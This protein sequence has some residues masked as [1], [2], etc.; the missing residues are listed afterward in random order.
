MQWWLPATQSV[1]GLPTLMRGVIDLAFE[2][3]QGWTIVD[4]KS[5]RIEADQQDR[6]VGYYRP[7]LLAYAKA[8]ELLTR[9]HV[10]QLAI[11]FTHTGQHRVIR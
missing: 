10:N 5:E 7:Q 11:L 6:L 1:S 4:Y 8:W 2:E 9:S 3:S